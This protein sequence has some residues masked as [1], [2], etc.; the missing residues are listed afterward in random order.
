MAN[1]LNLQGQLW[2]KI[3]TLISPALLL[4]GVVALSFGSIF[5][6]WSEN[7]LSYNA[8]VFNRL[9][10]A[11][12]AFGLWQFVKG[13]VERLKSNEPVQQQPYTPQD[14]WL[15]L[16]A[17]ICWA[18]TLLLIAWSLTQTSVAISTI[19]HNLA[20][21]FTSIGAWLLFGHRFNRQFLIGG[22][23]AIGGA[24]TIEFED[25]AIQLKPLQ[26]IAT[27]H[28]QGGIAAIVSAVFLAL[29]LLIV[30]QLRTKF[31]PMTIQLWIC[32]SAALAI[33]PV[34]LLTGERLFPVTQS[35]WLS[36]LALAFVCQVF[37]HGILTYSLNKFSSVVVSLAHLLEPVF[38][39]IFAFA[40]F[41]E[42]LSFSNGVGFA[43][44]LIGLYVAVSSFVTVDSTLIATDTKLRTTINS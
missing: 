15:L 9:W 35:G 38:S 44:V 19:L 23:I 13:I 20:P 21:I 5:V 36:V 6:K 12:I 31:P 11:A 26:R 22:A 33:L 4:I 2:G 10:L 29:Y 30:E 41:W 27:V 3:S 40:I 14:V 1:Q 34:L 18:A 8:T 37:G 24:I 17:G 42:R 7:G 25:L 39:S 16:S 32:G 28:V 43:V